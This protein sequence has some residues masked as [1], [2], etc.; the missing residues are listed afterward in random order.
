MNNI[1]PIRMPYVGLMP[2]SDSEEDA[3]FFFGRERKKEIIVANLIAS[4]LTLLYGPS[5]V[6]KSS[7]LRAGVAHHLRKQA[8]NDLQEGKLPKFAVVIFDSWRDADPL[9]GLLKEIEVAVAQLLPNRVIEPPLSRTTLVESLSNLTV[10]DRTSKDTQ[11]INLLIILDQF[12]EYFLYHA[13][14]AGPGS[15]AEEFPRAVNA[16]GIGVSFLISM[17]DDSITKLDRFKGRIPNLLANRLS[18]NYLDEVA[19]RE[20]IIRPLLQYNLLRASKPELAIDPEAV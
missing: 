6:G 19:A 13:N 17:R 9:A 1:A 15:F 5:G 8:K 4:R 2:Y 7:V 3:Q 11:T 18:V 10:P 14:E 20:A 12:E 16:P